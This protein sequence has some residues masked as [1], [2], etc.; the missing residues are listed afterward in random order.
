MDTSLTY[1]KPEIEHYTSTRNSCNVCSP[2]GASVAF[3]GIKG[4]VAL[5]HG[6]QG[7]STYIRRYLISHFKEP[8]DIAS[9][10]FSQDAT[11]FGGNKNFITGI[12]NIIK[13][14]NPDVIAI[15]ST[16][17]SETIGENVPMLI[18]GYKAQNKGK[19]LPDFVYASTPS[20]Q[21][22]HMD[23]FHEAVAATVMA[24]AEKSTC[25]E[26]INIFPGFVSPEDLRYLKEI[27]EDFFLEY[28]MV[29][30]YSETLD[31]PSWDEYK[32]IPDGGTPV[33]R[34]A[35]TGSALASIEFGYILQKGALQG[36]IKDQTTNPTAAE[37]LKSRF[38]IERYNMGLPI[39]IKETD[40]FFDTLEKLSLHETP[41]KYKMERGRLVD[42][43][44]DGHKYVFGKKAVVYGEEDFVIGM[45]SFLEEIG[46]KTVI[47]ATGGESGKMGETIKALTGKQDI[48][49]HSSADFEGIS[50]LARELKPDIMIG[51]S[52]GYYIARELGIPMVRVGFPVHDRMGGQRILHLGYRGAQILFDNIANALIQAK[53]DKSPVGYKYM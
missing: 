9:S 26:H 24:F 2:L 49:I 44:I 5:I 46:I 4:C 23:G 6:S 37:Y 7:C 38:G 19:K 31:N 40:K 15:A 22:S 47:C 10:N 50:A 35:E 29:P 51:N 21:G 1:K 13:Q 8:V 53:Q 33:S 43:Y 48:L 12:D 36:R 28:I 11:I 17:L 34:I 45:V 18:S 25:K 32:R 52:K 14:Y 39:G 27:L 30:D 41:K 42:A 3:K 16:C 20:Y